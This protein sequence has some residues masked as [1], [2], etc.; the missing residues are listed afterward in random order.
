M[1]TFLTYLL[2]VFYYLLFCSTLLLFQ[3]LQVVGLK[4]FGLNAQKRVVDIL[5]YLLLFHLRI[6]GT[7]IRFNHSYSFPKDRT[8]IFV[9]NHQS[10]YDIPPLIWYLREYA[11]KFIAKKELGKGIP[12]ISY[13]LRKGGNVL[14]DR[15][16]SAGALKAIK[17]FSKKVYENR[18]SVVIFP[19]GTRSRNGQTKH[20]HQNGLEQLLRE[21][22]DALIIP[23]SINN[24]WKLAKWNYF[25]IPLGVQM[26]LNVHPSIDPQNCEIKKSLGMV[27]K[28]ISEG[29]KN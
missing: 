6:V 13:H 23:I 10:T 24:S 5:N 1:S 11:P 25:P 20:F 21:I 17:K 22:P 4:L 15:K 7:S 26:E 16:N 19:E 9:S 2:S 8:L 27:E 3:P 14:I 18:W 29:V 12:S 28:I